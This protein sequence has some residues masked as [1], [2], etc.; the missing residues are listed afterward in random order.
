MNS[1]SDGDLF[2]TP[3]SLSYNSRKSNFSYQDNNKYS[4]EA[5]AN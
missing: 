4:I 5:Q 2:Y 1:K 3:K